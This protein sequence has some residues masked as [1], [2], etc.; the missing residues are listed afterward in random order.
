MTKFAICTPPIMFFVCPQKFVQALSAG[1]LPRRPQQ[2]ISDDRRILSRP[3]SV[4][5]MDN[6]VEN[7]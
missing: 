6:Q 3:G 5:K 1:K 7:Q 4:K 2:Q